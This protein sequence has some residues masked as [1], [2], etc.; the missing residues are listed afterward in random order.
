MTQVP[1]ACWKGLCRPPHGLW[2]EERE[3]KGSQCR[4]LARALKHY[5]PDFGREGEL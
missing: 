1:L 3:E 5:P 4:W 2:Q